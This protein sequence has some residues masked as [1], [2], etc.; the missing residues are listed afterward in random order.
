MNRFDIPIIAQIECR[1]IEEARELAYKVVEQIKI[2]NSTVFLADDHRKVSDG[3]RVVLLHPEN[4]HT[5]TI[6][7]ETE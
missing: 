6:P 2:D 5:D 7:E 1:S 3:R 4:G